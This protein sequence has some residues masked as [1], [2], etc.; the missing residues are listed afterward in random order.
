[1]LGVLTLLGRLLTGAL[2]D[3]FAGS[4]VTG[5][6]FAIAAVGV[7]VLSQA[8]TVTMGFAGA[9]LIGLGM[10]AEAD[11]MP[12]LVSRYFGLRSFSEIYGYTFTAY[13]FA[14]A[15]GPLIMGW[16]YDQLHS[17]TIALAG[18]AV[19]MFT[20]AAVLATL[21]RY[22]VPETRNDFAAAAAS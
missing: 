16:S 21:P 18:L 5:I 3:R 14:A 6:F 1:M 10:G 7:A 9:G 11:V 13:A 19:I 17:Y 12:Y 8:H 20:G 2:L 22:P 4:R 15:L